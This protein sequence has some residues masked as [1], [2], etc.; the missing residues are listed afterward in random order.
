MVL[1][2]IP[3]ANRSLQ[4]T[5]ISFKNTFL[6]GYSTFFS[7]F[8]F[9]IFLVILVDA[10]ISPVKYYITREIVGFPLISLCIIFILFTWAIYIATY[11]T[12][13]KRDSSFIHPENA[14]SNNDDGTKLGVLTRAL[15]RELP[16]RNIKNEMDSRIKED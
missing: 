3:S 13:R 12:S 11:V 6:Y 2:A 4:K 16:L 15:R 8:L 5:R 7:S 1:L 9:A 14:S 10:F